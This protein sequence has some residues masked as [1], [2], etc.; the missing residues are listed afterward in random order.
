M[1]RHIVTLYSC[2]FELTYLLFAYSPTS[3]K[4][5]DVIVQSGFPPA[6]SLSETQLSALTV[7]I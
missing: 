4:H 7:E 2:A 6:V 3:L 5:G 1:H